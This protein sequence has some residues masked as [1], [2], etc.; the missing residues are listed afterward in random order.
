MPEAAPASKQAYYKLNS[1]A[2][3]D[4]LDAYIYAPEMRATVRATV[5]SARAAKPRVDVLSAAAP[6]A[7]RCE[8]IV[9]CNY[10][11]CVAVLC[12]VAQSACLEASL[13]LVSRQL[14]NSCH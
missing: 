2:L 7:R 11:R 13:L 6:L 9:V 1:Q 12:G 3:N 5:R 4:T 14:S 10:V 8:L